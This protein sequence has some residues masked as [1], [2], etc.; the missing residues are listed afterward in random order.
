MDLSIIIVSYRTRDLLDRCL[1]S[2]AAVHTGDVETIV[3]DND[4]QDGTVE[5]LAERY[6]QVQV[7]PESTNLGFA[8]GVNRGAAQARGEVLVILNPDTEVRAGALDGLAGFL[9]EHPQVGAVGPRLV[10]PAG[11]VELSC[12]AFPSV[13]RVLAGQLGLARLFARTRTFGAYNMT[14]WD[15]GQARRVDWV[16][17]ACLVVTRAAWQQVGPLD[18][19]Y[20]MYFE[21]ADWCRRLAAVGLE[22]WYLPEAQIMHHE[23][24]SWREASRQRILASH[25]AAFRYFRKHHG[26]GAET[27]VRLS[28]AL[29]AL[30]RAGFW[31]AA[32][33]LGR[34]KGIVTDVGTHL[35]VARLALGGGDAP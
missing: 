14:W 11:E 19:D 30:A 9:R 26:R 12:H 5:M 4:S 17:G 34:R 18:E 6:P 29:S 22:C 15:H 27:V 1:A 16:S 32:K 21:D 23:A 28:T 2:L 24:A 20:F 13:A 8:G 3:L 31:L 35:A 25:R 33:P 7:I 10:G